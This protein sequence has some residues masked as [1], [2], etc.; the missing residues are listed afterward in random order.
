MNPIATTVTEA[1]VPASAV[2]ERQ[3]L[4]AP[5]K[6]RGFRY[7]WYCFIKRVFDIVSSLCALVILSPVILIACFAKWVEDGH[8]PLYISKRVGK[9]GKLFRFWK[10]RTMCPD[11]DKMKQQLIDMG[12]N[13]ADPPAFKMKNDPRITR[14]GRFLRKFSIDEIPQLLNVLN[15]TMSVVGPR[16]PLPNEVEQYTEVQRHRLDVKGG[17]LCFWQLR[18]DRNKLPFDD[19][20]R[21]D[22]EYI[23]KQ[24]IGLDLKI[25]F[26]GAWRV[27]FDHSGE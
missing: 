4:T 19:W 17:L 21:L 22:F 11:A 26:V 15:G 10:I 12:L 7:G 24:S 18:K 9:D 2:R 27:L 14:V 23:E 13:E 25:I 8:A 16:P 3:E 1:A 20:C 6:K 5:E